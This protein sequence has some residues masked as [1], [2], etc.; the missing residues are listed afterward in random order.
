LEFFTPTKRNLFY[1]R[2]LQRINANV[3]P[4]SGGLIISESGERNLLVG[5][6]G[7]YRFLEKAVR[8]LGT[9]R[10]GKFHQI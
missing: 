7:R 4:L 9:H 2:F 6:A 3:M 8:N 10:Q 1:N 5:A